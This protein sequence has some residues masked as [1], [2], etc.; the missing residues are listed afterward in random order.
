MAPPFRDIRFASADGLRLYGRDYQSRG[1]GIPIL[2]LAGLTRNVRD[3]E[4]LAEKI[5]ATRRLLAMDYRGRG[6]SGYAPD[7]SS[8]RV[9]VEADDALRFL[10]HLDVPR[11]AL[12]GTSRGGLVGMTIA[13]KALDRV[14]GLLFNDIGPVIDKAGLLRIR[15][16]L[17]RAP[18][19]A[20]WGEAIAALRR[21]HEGFDL[22]E[23]EWIAFAHRVYRD[24]NGL[25]RIDYDMR[26]GETFPSA[27]QIETAAAPDLWP[28]F[29][30]LAPLPCAVLRGENSDLLSEATVAEMARRHPG[31]IVQTV[32]HRGH[33]PFLDEPESLSAIREW[34][35]RV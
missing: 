23:S 24:E 34:L 14:S 17:G 2:C 11:A 18:A 15:S 13:A 29:N 28:L 8:Y 9:D 35:A 20:S 22:P 32:R 25:P 27:E 30:A 5:G 4:R 21:S 19:F 33:V 1:N 7:P 12:I 31:L 6:Q 3:F 16:Y 10:D 26:L